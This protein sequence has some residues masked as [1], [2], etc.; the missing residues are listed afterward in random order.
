MPPRHRARN[1][2]S[3][4]L[5]YQVSLLSLIRDRLSFPASP[6]PHPESSNSALTNSILQSCAGILGS[7]KPSAEETLEDFDHVN[8]VNYRGLWLCARAEIRAML[9]QQPL[10]SDGKVMEG[11]LQE[12]RGSIVHIASQLGLV[13]RPNARS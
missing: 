1:I 5:C 8:A 7:S 13:A 4:R 3:S 12:G 6:L 10:D 11:G 2:R 9:K